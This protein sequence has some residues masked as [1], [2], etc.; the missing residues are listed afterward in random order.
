VIGDA[1]NPLIDRCDIHTT[2]QSGI[3]SNDSSAVGLIVGGCSISSCTTGGITL[4]PPPRGSII[5]KNRITLCGVHGIS[6]SASLDS[7]ADQFVIGRNYV[8]LNTAHGIVILCE[9][10]NQVA[11]AFSINGNMVAQNGTHGIYLRSTN[12][13]EVC[14]F[15]ISGNVCTQNSYD[16]IHLGA[17]VMK[18]AVSSNICIANDVGSN[19]GAGIR[20]D[21]EDDDSKVSSVAVTGNVC[22]N[23]Y[24][25]TTQDFGIY[26]SDH[27]EL[28]TV[29]GNPVFD[30]A[31]DQITDLGSKN[32]VGHNPGYY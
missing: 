17:N 24:S 29:I 22:A 21:G 2:V 27:T 15:A 11:K 23:P 32:D 25:L 30:N 14:G 31:T 4:V 18:G 19:T 7:N 5:S 12:G 6:A 3:Y 8:W 26:L 13:G 20:L 10:G 9:Y 28:N 16:G 1:K